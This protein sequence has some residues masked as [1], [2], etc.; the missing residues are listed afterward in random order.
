MVKIGQEH[1]KIERHHYSALARNVHYRIT[2]DIR[3]GDAS[4]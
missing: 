1:D 2:R 4:F 3:N